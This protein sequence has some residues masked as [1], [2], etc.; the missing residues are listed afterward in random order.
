MTQQGPLLEGPGRAQRHKA[1]YWR[2]QVGHNKAL[3]W[4]GQVGHNDTMRANPQLEDAVI[5]MLGLGL[6]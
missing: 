4:R 2:G 6:G 1:L 5:L 3:Y